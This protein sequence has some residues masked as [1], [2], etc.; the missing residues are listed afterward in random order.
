[1]KT[2]YKIHISV[3]NNGLTVTHV[4]AYTMQFTN[5]QKLYSFLVRRYNE[6]KVHDYKFESETVMYR[7]R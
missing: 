7:I 1:M 5:F 3:R 6:A 2:I 4:E